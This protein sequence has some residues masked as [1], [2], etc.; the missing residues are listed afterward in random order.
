MFAVIDQVTGDHDVALRSGRS[1]AKVM[2]SV[3]VLQLPDLHL[4]CILPFSVAALVVDEQRLLMVPWNLVTILV[5]RS[6]A[7]IA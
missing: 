7:E 5:D 1:Q 6:S 4:F 3:L 2:E